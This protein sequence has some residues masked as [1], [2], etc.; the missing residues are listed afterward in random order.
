MRADVGISYCARYILRGWRGVWDHAACG[1]E[2]VGVI[3]EEG[4]EWE[5]KRLADQED[6]PDVDISRDA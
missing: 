1:E 5:G 2:G 3:R 4:E 6:L